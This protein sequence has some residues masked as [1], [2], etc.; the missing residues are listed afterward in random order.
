MLFFVN[1]GYSKTG[2]VR[3]YGEFSVRGGIIDFYSPLE[4]LDNYEVKKNQHLISESY[5]EA[6]LSVCK[7]SHKM[8][9]EGKEKT[10]M[11]SLDVM[12]TTRCGM[13][14]ES[15]SN[16][17]QY[18]KQHKNF[19]HENILASIDIIRKNV[20]VISEFRLIGGEPLMNKE[21]AKIANGISE[22]NP[23]CE[24]FI[25]SNGTI[26]PKDE[27]LES[28]YGKKIKSRNS[29]CWYSGNI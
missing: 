16:L 28:F 8:Y 18:Y 4:L 1:N 17:M 3:E 26:A 12:I 25:Y 2:T 7:N 19:D 29:W 21:W 6:R 5:M 11:R 10:Y 9:L 23:E 20:D 14:C 24:I 27:Q 15:C 22:R 13:K